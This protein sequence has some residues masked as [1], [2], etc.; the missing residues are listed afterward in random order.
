MGR[1]TEGNACGAISCNMVPRNANFFRF[2][3]VINAQLREVTGGSVTLPY[4][5]LGQRSGACFLRIIFIFL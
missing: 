4:R 3:L 2:T 5:E 1:G